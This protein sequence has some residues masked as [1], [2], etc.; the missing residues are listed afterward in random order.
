MAQEPVWPLWYAMAEVIF[1][2]FAFLGLSLS[3][4]TKEIWLSFYQFLA[5]S[6]GFSL[7]F[8]GLHH[9]EGTA[10]LGMDHQ[11]Q[12]SLRSSPVWC[13][14]TLFAN[15]VYYCLL[16]LTLGFASA[17]QPSGVSTRVNVRSGLQVC[18][19]SRRCGRRG[20]TRAAMHSSF[21]RYLFGL[22]LVRS[23]CR[24][25]VRLSAPEDEEH[26]SGTFISPGQ[27]FLPMLAWFI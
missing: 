17:C 27:A 18:P 16:P 1:Y 19:L 11:T 4:E 26:L 10:P 2:L 21:S 13:G 14:A 9:R 22:P 3:C 23:V 7:L 25:W 20:H 5:A 8:Q 24:G 15:L 12:A 6:W